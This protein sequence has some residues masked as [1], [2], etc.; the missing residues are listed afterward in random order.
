[1]D[2]KSRY[3]DSMLI[4]DSKQSREKNELFPLSVG[5][6][7]AARGFLYSHGKNLISHSIAW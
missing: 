2:L 3:D 6:E 5:F 1:M 7:F 4:Y